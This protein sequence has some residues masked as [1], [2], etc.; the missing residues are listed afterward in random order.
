MTPCFDLCDEVSW[1]CDRVWIEARRG[2]AY[3]GLDASYQELVKDGMFRGELLGRLA[4]SRSDF[5]KGDFDNLRWTS[6]V[7]ADGASRPS[8]D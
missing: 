5:M 1:S 6:G 3:K 4:D 7:K 8:V 2:G